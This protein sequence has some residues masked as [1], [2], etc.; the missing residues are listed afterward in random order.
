MAR[1]RTF[2][3]ACAL[4]LTLAGVSNLHA[5]T[6][7]GRYV[8]VAESGQIAVYALNPATGQFKAIQAVGQSTFGGI[9][10]H[11]SDKFL[12][13]ST[14]STSIA[15]YKIGTNGLLTQIA[16]SPFPTTYASGW[17]V[18]TPSGKFAWTENYPNNAEA[19]SV[20]TTTG[21]LTSLGPV[22]LGSGTSDVE[23]TPKGNFLY[24]ANNGDSTISGFAINATTGALTA[25]PG[26]P[27]AG[28][29]GCASSLIHPSG[30][31]VYGQNFDATISAFSINQKT[32][33]L[34]PVPGSPFPG[35]P[36]AGNTNIRATPNGLFIYDEPDTG[37]IT[38]FSV[39]L[40]TGALT[41]I[42]GSPF[43]PGASGFT[44][45]PDPGSNFLY[46]ENYL[47]DAGQAPIMTFSIDPGTGALTQI[48][49][50]GL[51]G[52]TASWLAFTTGAAAVKYTP[53]FAYITNS[54]GNSITEYNIAGGGL[55]QLT[56]SPI[57]DTNGPQAS[58]ATT[59]NK[60]LYT[61][62]TNGSVSEHKIASTG[63]LSK[64]K[65]SPITGL[66]NPVAMA[67][68]FVDTLSC[69]PYYWVYAADQAANNV[70]VYNRNPTTGVL[71]VSDIASAEGIGPSAIALDPFGAFT[72]LANTGS[73][74]LYIG[75]PCVGFLSTVATGTSPVAMLI[76]PSNQ[77]VYVANSGDGT[78]SGYALTLASPYLTPLSGSPWTAGTT[79]SALVTDPWGNYLYVANSGSDTISA[80]TINPLSG[81]LAAISGPFSTAGS[82]SALAVS[83]N[84]NL[85]YVTD[86]DIGELQQFTIN[87]DGSLT[88][89]GGGGVGSAPTSVTTIGT[90]K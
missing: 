87:S 32:G 89:A 43:A 57:T 54:G 90:Y 73:G 76:D 42:A 86:K 15:G 83:N 16:G 79:P 30:K 88:S 80:F 35:P 84:G 85:L 45:L 1:K 25:V 34:T 22:A 69:G 8:Y 74:D 3:L 10:V 52:Q 64:I 4:V 59:D 66:T 13:V 33:T 29:P 71:S 65:G 21:V 77:F 14:G 27:F 17:I 19:F 2:L 18:F 26:S 53:T 38:G 44:A 56:G 20:D 81:A 23:I 70:D 49:S 12:Y 51:V 62:N 9:T 47:G 63:A 72:L 67:A 36:F 82:P 55:T 11:P 6:K 7:V 46:L 39:N 37:G 40:S 28:G 60:F 48:G 78:V 58:V 41:Q 31:F 50:Q 68:R 5:T 75:A 61:G 24:A